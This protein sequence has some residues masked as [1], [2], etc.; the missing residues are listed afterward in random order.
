MKEEVY[1][2]RIR[3]T[4]SALVASFIINPTVTILAMFWAR[5]EAIRLHPTLSAINPPTISRAIADP[6]VGDIFAYWML[7]VGAAQAFAFYRLALA[8]R[9]TA[10]TIGSP[11]H[12]AV[13]SVLLGLTVLAEASAVVGVIMLSQYTGSISDYLHQLGS[14]LMFA[15]NGFGIMFCGV[16]VWLDNKQR[17]DRERSAADAPLPYILCFH[18][19]FAVVVC[20][21]SI[22]FT[23]LFF[24]FDHLERLNH[25]FFH[26]LFVTVEVTLLALSVIY[27]GGFVI[28]MYRYERYHLRRS[29][30]ARK[31]VDTVGEV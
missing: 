6:R 16:F 19:W 21:A 14:Y 27:L 10:L 20:T 23:F 26:L 7:V 15:G 4:A 18:T 24:A 3:I 2:W 22:I 31:A 11:R 29:S 12:R 28:P 30:P 1:S 5:S 17:K 13:M 8:L 25:Y 9:D